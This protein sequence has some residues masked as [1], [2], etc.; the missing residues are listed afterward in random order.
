MSRLRVLSVGQCGFDH[1]QIS[2]HLRQ[3][4][5]AD[6]VGADTVGEALDVLRAERFDL[7]LVNRI[8]D[9]DDAPGTDLIRSIKADPALAAT[10]VMMVSNY[11]YA[12]NDAIAL[13]AL[14]GFGKSALTHRETEERLRAVFE[15]RTS[16]G[17]A[18][19]MV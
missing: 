11:A 9:M 18:E 17:T 1:G 10:P 13:G 12:Q 2:R 14:P 16:A 5:G 3:A 6:V 19:P 8:G 15:R 4:F 7:V